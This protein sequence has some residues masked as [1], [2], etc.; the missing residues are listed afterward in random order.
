MITM[1]EWPWSCSFNDHLGRLIIHNQIVHM[2]TWLKLGNGN[3]NVLAN[4]DARFWF[5]GMHK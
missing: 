4:M 3:K 5:N 2:T 1:D